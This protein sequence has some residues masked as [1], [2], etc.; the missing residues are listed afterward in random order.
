MSKE[1]QNQEPEQTDNFDPGIAESVDFS[2]EAK[3]MASQPKED[4]LGSDFNSKDDP[5]AGGKSYEDAEQEYEQ[6]T[7]HSAEAESYEMFARGCLTVENIATP[8]ILATVNDDL[9][10]NYKLTTQEINELTPLL[11]ACLEHEQ[12]KPDSPWFMF[13]IAWIGMRLPQALSGWQRKKKRNN[14]FK[15]QYEA[16][17]KD[18]KVKSEPISDEDLRKQEAEKGI[19]RCQAEDCNNELSPSQKK[20]CSGSCRS[21]TNARATKA[22]A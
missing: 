10:E 13:F 1:K 17:Q 2:A 11:A 22:A 16:R 12:W 20:Y 18:E 14:H 9:P 5:E 7:Q 21:R 19:R 6:N 4:Y 8:R 3:K 15:D